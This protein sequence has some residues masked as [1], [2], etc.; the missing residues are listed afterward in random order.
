MST[1]NV[2]K[3]NE[4]GTTAFRWWKKIAGLGD[5]VNYF[6]SYIILMC[7]PDCV[8]GGFGNFLESLQNNNTKSKTKSSKRSVDF[9]FEPKVNVRPKQNRGE[10]KNF[11]GF[12]SFGCNYII[13]L[14]Y[15]KE[16]KKIFGFLP[17]SSFITI[18]RS[19][20][21]SQNNK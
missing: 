11:I 10:R 17:G 8:G 16:K 20:L 4:R 9:A 5:R 21:Q 15:E 6:N 19:M 1:K 3:Y 2:E 7:K 13:C 14:K 12:L 18:L